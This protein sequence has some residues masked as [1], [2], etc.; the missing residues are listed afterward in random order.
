MATTIVNAKVF[1]GTKTQDWTSVRFADGV[2]T[3][4]S[5]V[6]VAREGD[7]V[8]DA[9]G[10]TVFP[11]L[12]DAH[13]HLVPGALAQSLTF[14]VTTV[15]DMFSKPDVVAQAKEQAGSRL[16]VADV[17]SSG[18]GATAPGGHPSTM[19]PPF[20]TLTAAEQAEQ[21]VADRIADGSDYLKIISGVG[22][23]W[24]SLDS[25][26]IT[27]LV[28]AA[29]ARGLVVVAHV[30]STAGVEE[31]VSAGVDVVA[32][33]PAATELAESSV[34]RMAEAGI[35]V[36]PTLATIENTLGEPGGAAV[37]ADPRLAEGLG[38][39]WKRWLTTGQRGRGMPP[40]RRA[41]DNVRRLADA[42]VTLLAGTD[43]PNPGTV[44]GA[45]LHRELELLV[46]CGI[47]PAR[48][49]AAA[50]AEPAR[51]FG[52]TDR[53]RVA[54]GQRADLVL[55]SGDPLA[56]ITATRAIDRV[57]RAGTA[58][59]RRA[60]VASAAEAEQLDAFASQVAKVVAA[61]RQGRQPAR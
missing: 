43:A 11:G 19:Y 14:G 16:D 1:D 31:V 23:R 8:I 53:G 52:L 56:D 17:R 27:A 51:V 48:A 35:V 22:G 60:F 4:C 40:Y 30:S 34:E 26:T 24:P 46:R 37:V 3:Q 47:S 15:L 39:V 28:T 59:D 32:H 18:V 29:H 25:G 20:P 33:V 12:I 42:G 5:A 55:V 9:A 41:E 7:D 10:G 13:V 54:P 45:S 21:F 2:I 57:W 44:F 58:C 50:T 61:V 6:S 38:D 36:G 49:L